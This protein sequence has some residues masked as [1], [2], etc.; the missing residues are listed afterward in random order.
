MCI[1]MS[2]VGIHIVY[3]NMSSWYFCIVCWYND[4]A[5]LC[6]VRW[7]TAGVLVYDLLVFMYRMLGYR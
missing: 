5:Y 4:V 2:C 7:Y 1:Y 3:W 6:I